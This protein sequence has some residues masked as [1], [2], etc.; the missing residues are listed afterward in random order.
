MSK[1]SN[2]SQILKSK[3][4]KFN[5][6]FEAAYKGKNYQY[7]AKLGPHLSEKL[8]YRINHMREEN[9]DS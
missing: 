5:L 1:N 6:C 4:E 3:Y 8:C 9:E 2:L 7:F